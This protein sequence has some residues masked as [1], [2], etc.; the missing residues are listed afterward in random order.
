M[1]FTIKSQDLVRKKLSY[2]F[3]LKYILAQL[4]KCSFSPFVAF[5][6]RTFLDS[7]FSFRP[8]YSPS[9][10]YPVTRFKA[11]GARF[12]PCDRKRGG[13]QLSTR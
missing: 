2:T 6:F 9:S 13:H 10:T 12:P 3:L 4:P 8:H 5:S 1:H 11:K 7:P